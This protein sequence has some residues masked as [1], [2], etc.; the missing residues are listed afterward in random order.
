MDTAGLWVLG[1]VGFI[2]LIGLLHRAHQSNSRHEKLAAI[3]RSPT[4]SSVDMAWRSVDDDAFFGP[5]IGR[6]DDE[7]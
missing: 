1:A 4:L 6:R 3:G 2:V 5:L 7:D